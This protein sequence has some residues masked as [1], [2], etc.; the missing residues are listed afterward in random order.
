MAIFT[1][2]ALAV[3][4]LIG[5]IFGLGYMPLTG[6]APIWFAWIPTVLAVSTILMMNLAAERIRK[7]SKGGYKLDDDHA[8]TS[9]LVSVLLL[10][11]PIVCF[12]GS[13]LAVSFG[14]Q[15]LGLWLYRLRFV[16]SWALLAVGVGA[17]LVI[18][19]GLVLDPIVRRIKMRGQTEAPATKS[20]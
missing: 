3:F 5:W 14:Q 7:N 10:C 9:F 15:T 8:L 2:L 20:V 13:R 12:Q 4:A 11:W 1:T 16:P 19:N 18:L 6:G 17:G